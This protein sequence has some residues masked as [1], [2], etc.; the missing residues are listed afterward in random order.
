MDAPGVGL[1]STAQQE[2]F[3]GMSGSCKENLSYTSEQKLLREQVI[4][5]IC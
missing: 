2:M 4:K 5:L 3:K 1:L